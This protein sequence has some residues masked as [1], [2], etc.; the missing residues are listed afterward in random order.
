MTYPAPQ[1]VH[2]P[3]MTAVPPVIIPHSHT[4][5]DA[6][7]TPDTS[8]QV[9]TATCDPIVSIELSDIAAHTFRTARELVSRLADAMEGTFK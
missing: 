6:P 4:L 3:R 9:A 8:L 2:M 7:E 5:L 1:A